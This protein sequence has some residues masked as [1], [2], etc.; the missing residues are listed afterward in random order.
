MSISEFQGKMPIIGNRVYIAPSAV[1]I[2]E[3]SLGDD[4]SIWPT[5]VVRGDV[6]AIII[7]ERTNIQDGSVCHVTHV[8][9]YMPGGSSLTV[10]H[11]VTV[12][13][14]VIL[15]ACTIGN[16]CLI[17]MGST[18]LDGAVIQ[19]GVILGAA[20]LV[21]ENKVLESGYLYMGSPAKKVRP[22]SEKEK[23]FLHYSAAHYVTLKNKY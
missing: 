18:I 4:C 5:T 8:G 20:S 2:G 10:G 15:H 1:V 21:T 11:D 23:A 13:H 3:V 9:Q 12:G 22:L 16:L 17:G 14:R 7:G 19:D 6:N